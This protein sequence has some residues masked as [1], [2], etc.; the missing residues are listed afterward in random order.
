MKYPLV[1]QLISLCL[2]LL[3]SPAHAPGQTL[4][5]Q[6]SAD[7]PVY[8]ETSATP[9][10]NPVMAVPA[11]ELKEVVAHYSADRDG[12]RRRYDVQYSPARRERLQA[13][14][15]DWTNHLQEIDFNRLGIEGRID[16]VLLNNELRYELELLNREEKLVNEM[17]VFIPFASDIIDLDEARRRLERV[18]PPVVATTLNT[19]PELI[20]QARKAVEATLEKEEGN[21]GSGPSRIVVLRASRAL[22]SL[23]KRLER[24]FKNYAG[25]D[26]IFTWWNRAPYE[27]VNEAL[28]EYIKFLNEQVIG[29]KEGED[30]P[31]VGDPIGADGMRADLN[32]EMISYTPEEL[33]AIAENEF[34]WCEA[35][36]INASREMGFGDDWKAALEKVKT[37]HRAPGDQPDMVRDLAFEAVAFLRERD[38]ITIPKLAEEIW[39]VE[40]MSPEMQKV[41]PFFLGGEVI[42][43]AF[44]T[45]DM[46][47]E[48]KLMSMRGNNEH[49]ARA[50]VHHELIPGHHL[51]GFMTRRYNTHR[52]AFSTPFWG[53]GWALY[54]E[55]LLWDLGFPQTPEDRVGMLFWRSHRAARIIFSLNFHLGKMTPQE[56]IDFLVDRVGHERANASAEVR[57]SFNGSYSPLYQV[58][59][60][61]GGIQIRALHKTLVGSGQMT[62]RVFHDTILQGGRMPIEM[63]RAR[64]TGEAPVRNF[65]AM[66]RFY[67]E[68]LD[69][70]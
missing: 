26:P 46:A 10:L 53:E 24:W 12:L 8:L 25:Y 60:M 21:E 45:D 51:Q 58:A 14:Y 16:Y 13:F 41:A 37:L 61:I 18:D 34:A 4:Q 39:R 9:D 11:S 44:P 35:E 42:R 30:P 40:M 64:I 63:V 52:R 28:T 48:D 47:H 70:Q 32:Y 55:M 49:F 1:Y 27:K 50:T 23:K 2:F 3:I 33:I 22:E 7:L 68:P 20:E 62:N 29:F 31:I 17:Q 59:Y 15:K 65:K 38:L 19:L 57:R 54:W 56:C 69:E 36:M 43:V 67:G 66:W 6:Q 5:P